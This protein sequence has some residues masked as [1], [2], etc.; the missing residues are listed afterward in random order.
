MAINKKLLTGNL[1]GEVFVLCIGIF[2]WFLDNFTYALILGGIGISLA[3]FTACW[4]LI[5]EKIPIIIYHIIHLVIIAFFVMNF[6]EFADF[7]NQRAVKR[8]QCGQV[9]NII[10]PFSKNIPASFELVNS[11]QRIKFL[12]GSIQSDIEKYQGQICV[13]YSFDER[14]VDDPYIHK[15]TAYT[16]QN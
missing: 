1:L 15:V 11:Q 3:L 9:E 13:E 2:F 5:D 8:Q 14:W 10:V 12:Y 4:F 16:V 7:M 6:L